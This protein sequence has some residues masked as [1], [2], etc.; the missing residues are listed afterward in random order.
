LTGFKE[1]TF[2]DK[3]EQKE[4]AVKCLEMLDI[5]KPYINKFKSKAA[6]PCFFE[7]Y[8]GFY[9]DQEPEIYNKMK[10]LEE[11]HGFLVYALTHE[12]TDLGETWSMLCVPKSAEGIEDLLGRFNQ[13]EYYVL[14]Y[15]W[16]KSNPLF[17]ELGDIVVKSFGG[18]LKRIH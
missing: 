2:M 1:D 3:I 15:V 4:L 10:E 7:H 5:Y 8:A 12:I 14:A 16:N 13:N 11:E 6:L 17:S 18:G 9:V